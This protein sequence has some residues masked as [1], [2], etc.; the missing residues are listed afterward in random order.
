[1]RTTIKN[2][3]VEKEQTMIRKLLFA[4]LVAVSLVTF[5]AAESF[6]QVRPLPQLNPGRTPLGLTQYA[7]QVTQVLPGGSAAMQGI[8]PGDIIVSVNN[9][10]VRS[11][12]DLNFLL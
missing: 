1:M 7:L 3:R 11:L 8:E 4:G 12:T 5:G 6:A 2:K 10:P 9:V